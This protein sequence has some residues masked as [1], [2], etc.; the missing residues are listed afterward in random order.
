MS[1]FDH[2]MPP[3]L[4]EDYL[5]SSII[6]VYKP[7]V[8]SPHLSLTTPLR[9][10][11]LYIS[12]DKGVFCTILS[13][14]SRLQFLCKPC[15][16]ISATLQVNLAVSLSL[17]LNTRYSAPVLLPLTVCERYFSLTQYI[18]INEF[19]FFKGPNEHIWVLLSIWSW[20]MTFTALC[21]RTSRSLWPMSVQKRRSSSMA[22]I[23]R[24]FLFYYFTI[25]SL[26]YM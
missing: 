24:S 21:C 14:Q 25:P 19:W 10:T 3:H 26:T 18:F 9:L 8:L 4:S 11:L 5:R 1:Q 20:I 2:V 13:R 16:P 6:L 22:T 23:V 15:P 7:F 12:S 17:S